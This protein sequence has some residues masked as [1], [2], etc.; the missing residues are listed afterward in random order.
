MSAYEKELEVAQRLARQ[1]G[2]FALQYRKGEIQV[3]NKCDDSPVTVADKEGEKTIVNG[4]IEA[5]PEAF[6]HFLEDWQRNQ[7]HQPQTEAHD[8]AHE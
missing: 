8:T 5:F 6:A 1:A 2:D 4:L 7:V 3:E